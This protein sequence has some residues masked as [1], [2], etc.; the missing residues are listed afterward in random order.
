MAV[1][2]IITL[3]PFDPDNIV[4]VDTLRQQRILCDW[5]VDAIESW[6]EQ[7]RRGVKGLYWVF[8]KDGE[9]ART[10]LRLPPP[11][12]EVINRTGKP[13]P[14]PPYRDFRP[15]GHAS[16]DWEDYDGD[17]SLASKELGICTIATF[18]IL[19]SQQ[20]LGLGNLV[21]KALEEKAV[22]LGAKEITLNTLCGVAG[23]T[24]ELWALLGLEYDPDKTRLNEFWYERLNYKVYKRAPR[25]KDFAPDGTAIVL[26]A[27]FMR[28]S[29]AT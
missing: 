5:A 29:L 17:A 23:K 2:D 10:K 7:A 6:R 11:E 28:K 13:G 20:G 19:A 26:P 14:P 12:I 8:P 18:Y 21:M 15:L 4:H 9:A 24:K 16:L 27:V 1:Q 25:Y 3:V 22:E